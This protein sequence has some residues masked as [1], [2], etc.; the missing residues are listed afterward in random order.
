[1]QADYII[2]LQ[3]I[4]ANR[5]VGGLRLVKSGEEAL[6]PYDTMLSLTKIPERRLDRLLDTYQ[7]RGA[8]ILNLQS[9]SATR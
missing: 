2:A 6:I 3:D 9:T 7:H 5:I 1:M 8:K 4:I